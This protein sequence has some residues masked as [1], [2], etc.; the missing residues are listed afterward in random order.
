MFKSRL[1]QRLLR[2]FEDLDDYFCTFWDKGGWFGLADAEVAAHPGGLR[3]EGEVALRRDGEGCLWRVAAQLLVARRTRGSG[4]VPLW[5]RGEA[6]HDGPDDLVR[7]HAEYGDDSTIAAFAAIEKKKGWSDEVRVI[8][9]G[10]NGVDLSLGIRVR[11]QVRYSTAADTKVAVGVIADEGRP[12]FSI[13]YGV[14][15]A[16]C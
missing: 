15:M 2:A 9:D 6:G 11:D 3:P 7:R 12:Y 14:L 1:I 5:E 4:A 8:F 13:E 10:T 16:H